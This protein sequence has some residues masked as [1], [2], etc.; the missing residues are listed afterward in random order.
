MSLCVRYAEAGPGF[1][2]RFAGTLGASHRA[3]PSLGVRAS[4]APHPAIQRKLV[5][6]AR[7]TPECP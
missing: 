6:R 5:F 2:V 1:G 4:L 7:E 3:A